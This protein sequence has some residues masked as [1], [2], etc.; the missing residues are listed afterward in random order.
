MALHVAVPAADG[1][2]T[3][4]EV[5]TPP[6]EVQVTALLYAPVPLTVATQVE[7]W[8]VLI[9]A[10][11]ATTVIPVTVATTGVA[12]IDMLAVPDFV[13]SCVEVA[14]Q[15]PVPIPEG[16]KTPDCVIVP[17]VAVHVTDVVKFP[18]PDTVLVHVA[19]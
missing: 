15:L 9:D 12:V 5:I 7:V 13:L 6:D 17:P 18:L 4:A 1:V 8:A 2:K 19:V 14:V 16:V 10:G 3:P 11:L